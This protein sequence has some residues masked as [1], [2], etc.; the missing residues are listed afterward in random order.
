MKIVKIETIINV[1]DLENSDLMRTITHHIETAIFS[2]ENPLGG[3]SFILYPEKKGNGVKPIKHSFI[4]KLQ[5]FGWEPEA[6]I[7]LVV[8]TNR[9]GPI[10]A[11]YPVND[12][13]FAVE[14]ET[15]NI[16]S[17]H[18]AVNKIIIGMLK[19]K[20]IGGVLILPSRKM[21]EYLTDRVGNY[22]ELEPYFPVWKDANYNIQ[23]G[24]LK[25]IEI[26]HDGESQFVPKIPKG[27]D[28]RAL[29]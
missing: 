26:E 1:G 4:L 9:P 20:L 7:D 19:G 18:R 15:G 8:T 21:Y 5:E 13:F 2:I 28:G 6:K 29:R 12:K 27:T 23:N 11:A 3:G 24:I 10:D 17:S 14:W 16:S 22:M 25:I